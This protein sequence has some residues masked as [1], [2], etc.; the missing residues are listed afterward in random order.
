[1]IILCV[2]RNKGNLIRF[3]QAKSYEDSLIVRRGMVG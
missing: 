2:V 3:E 1:M